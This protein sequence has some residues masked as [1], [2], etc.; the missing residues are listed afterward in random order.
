M[1]KI[2]KKELKVI[3]FLFLFISCIIQSCLVYFDEEGKKEKM[4]KKEF[5]GLHVWKNNNCQ[6]CHKIHGFG[7][8][9]ASDL[10]NKINCFE[11]KTLN[12]IL[13]SNNKEMPIFKLKKKDIEN[14]SLYLQYINKTGN[15]NLINKNKKIPWF[16]NKY[17]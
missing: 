9:S 13:L 17:E 12:F 8:F 16:E 4:N 6:S 5:R 7:G 10:T 15:S 14:L 1:I 3:I 11:N 2:Y